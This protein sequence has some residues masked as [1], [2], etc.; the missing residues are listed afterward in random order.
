M[1]Y[2]LNNVMKCNS[3]VFRTSASAPCIPSGINCSKNELII[4]LINNVYFSQYE[5]T[6]MEKQ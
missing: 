6:Y 3:V 1:Y 5:N 4:E 2:Y